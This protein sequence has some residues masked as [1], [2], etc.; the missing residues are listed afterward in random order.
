MRRVCR[1]R[2]HLCIEISEHRHQP[3]RSSAIELARDIIE[4]KER[5]HSPCPRR[6][7]FREF[8]RED[9]RPDL[10][11][12]PIV[13]GR[14]PINL[15]D[16]IIRLGSRQTRSPLPL[17]RTQRSKCPTKGLGPR[18]FPYA[19]CTRSIPERQGARQTDDCLMHLPNIRVELGKQRTPT[20]REGRPGSGK[21]LVQNIEH[22]VIDTRL[23]GRCLLV[24]CSSISSHC[25]EMCRASRKRS[26]IDPS[27]SLCWLSRDN[28]SILRR[29]CDRSNP[30]KP[31]LQRRTPLLVEL[32]R[33]PSLNEI[34]PVHAGDLL[35][36]HPARHRSVGRLP[37]NQVSGTGATEWLESCEVVDRFQTVG[38]SLGVLPMKN[39]ELRARVQVERLQVP[40]AACSETFEPHLS[41]EPH[42]HHHE[43]R[44]FI[45]GSLHEAR[46]EWMCERQG[47]FLVRNHTE[48]LL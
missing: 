18:I 28:L 37:L 26:T 16:D 3:T 38:L 46:G 23:Q 35:I 40:K 20:F 4:K 9:K 12:G 8:E 6:H 10:P 14:S 7:Q 42:G 48:D 24:E 34:H 41:V 32:Q 25:I 45:L 15:D 19:L 36:A 47:H 33:T 2:E 11:T 27:P 5:R 13:A 31:V 21:L 30:G 43:E 1:R 44:G 39:D 17:A 29:E 22:A